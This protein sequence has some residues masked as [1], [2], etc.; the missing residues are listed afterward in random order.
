VLSAKS[1]CSLTVEPWT[2]KIVGHMH[3]TIE[4]ANFPDT[5][6]VAPKNERR[7]E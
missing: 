2:K 5:V 4:K 7:F 1:V 3:Q 6:L